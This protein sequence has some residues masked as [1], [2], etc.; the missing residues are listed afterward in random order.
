MSIIL[1]RQDLGDLLTTLTEAS[2]AD[3]AIRGCRPFP[4][5]RGIPVTYW[6]P[7][8]TVIQ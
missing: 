4:E 6:I 7:V 1:H 5:N 3:P 8:Q 2:I